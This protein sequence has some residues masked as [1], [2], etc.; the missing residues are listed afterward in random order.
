MPNQPTNHLPIFDGHNDVLLALYEGKRGP[1]V[2]FFD[3]SADGHIDLPRAREGGFGGGFFAVYLPPDPSQPA[4]P[5][6]DDATNPPLPPPLSLAYAQR[7]TMAMTAL[8]FQIENQSQGQVKVVRTADELA[9]C[10]SSGIMAAI[11]HFEGAEPIDPE[12]HAL[13]VFYQAGL[14]S[15]GPVWSRANAFA[16]G[17]PFRFPHSPDTGPG[18]TDAGRALVRECNRLGI[19]IDLSHINEQGFW[20]VAK[21]SD[22]PLVATHSNVHAL[23]PSPRNLTDRQLDAIRE[24]D[25]M[26]GLNFFV[27][28]LRADGANNADTPLE[29]MVQ[30]IDYLVEKLGI[31][32]VGIGSDFDGAR[33]PQAIGDVAGLPKLVAALRQSGFDDASL[34]KLAYENWLRVLRKTWKQ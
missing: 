25:G 14:R 10:L 21:I 3:R 29:V 31:E 23:C 19:M 22:A 33:V 28:F 11:L 1:G 17:V 16:E 20:D 5:E 27:G 12:L 15:I 7:T 24:S 26:V 2:T 9:A 18:L 32:R 13:E 30:H 34:R 8:L 4:P 6:P